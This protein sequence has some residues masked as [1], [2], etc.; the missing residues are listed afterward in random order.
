MA[1]VDAVVVRLLATTDQYEKQMQAVARAAERAASAAERSFANSNSRIS[2]GAASIGQ[3][4]EK[5][6]QAASRA[7]G[8]LSFQLNDIA[9]GMTG[10]QSPFQIMMQQGSQVVQVMQSVKE[11]GGSMGS[12]V[13]AALKSMV[14]PIAIISFALI[15]ATAYLYDFFFGAEEKAKKAEKSFND[16][17]RGIGSMGEKFKDF[18]LPGTEEVLFKIEAQAD[19]EDAERQVTEFMTAM[20]AKAVEGMEALDIDPLRDL[21]FHAQ[22]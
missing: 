6:F 16:L 3:S 19:F 12:V 5:G 7:A 2:S 13:V 14:N 15:A 20:N 22:R 9:V 8:Q 4:S 21:E 10:G 17:A 18:L 11:A 1:D